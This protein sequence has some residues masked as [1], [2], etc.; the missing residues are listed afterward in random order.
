MKGLF[1]KKEKLLLAAWIL[2]EAAFLVGIKWSD[3][4]DRTAL[5]SALEYAAVALDFA[6]MGLF[7]V[8][9]GQ[10]QAH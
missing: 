3:Q 7:L 6:V 2:L 5:S 9:Y 10:E 8:R 4:A 1:T